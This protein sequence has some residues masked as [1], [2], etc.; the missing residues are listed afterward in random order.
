M[1]MKTTVC[2]PN[3]YG[4][5]DAKVGGG[6]ALHVGVV[7]SREV[8]GSYFCTTGPI[9]GAAS[10]QYLFS[11]EL[12]RNRTNICVIK[13]ITVSCRIS[14]AASSITPALLGAGRGDISLLSGGGTPPN[15]VK[16]RSSQQNAKIV[17]RQLPTYTGGVIPIWNGFTPGIVTGTTSTYLFSPEQITMPGY[18]EDG[19]MILEPGE[20][21]IVYA[22][23]NNTGITHI[24]NC[25]W[26]A[27]I[28]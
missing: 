5:V 17:L 13:R 16:A 25:H 10:V 27:C 28:P 8:I 11:I 12:P 20:C 7:S 2:G 6:G 23:T 22:N 3:G 18:T 24:V 26:Q 15:I 1:A 19:D 9:T 21:F 14:N 4:T